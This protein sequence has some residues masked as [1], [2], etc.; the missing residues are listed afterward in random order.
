MHEPQIALVDDDASL[1]RS[2]SNLLSSAG[3]TVA[4]FESAERFLES[5]VVS[6]VRCLVLDLRLP[7]MSGLQLLQQLSTL[8]LRI[9]TLV[10]T[11]CGDEPTRQRCLSAGA[12]AF[13]A[14][15]F[16]GSE[17]VETIRNMLGS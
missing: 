10:L 1:R 14:K 8:E 3:L 17:L 4:S 2:V 16:V 7:G 13:L 15:P 12:L 9:P 6:S 11:A 5:A